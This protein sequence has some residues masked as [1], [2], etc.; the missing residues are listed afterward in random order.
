[1]LPPE[2]TRQFQGRLILSLRQ[3]QGAQGWQARIRIID[4]ELEERAVSPE[5]PSVTSSS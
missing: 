2:R 5:R 1:M 3:R 4:Y